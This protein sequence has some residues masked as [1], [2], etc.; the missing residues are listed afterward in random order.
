MSLL[1]KNLDGREAI[2]GSTNQY[3]L[4]KGVGGGHKHG[5]QYIIKNRGEHL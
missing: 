1:T 2:Y 3:E 4:L 5:F